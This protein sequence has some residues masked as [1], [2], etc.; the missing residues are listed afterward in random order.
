MARSSKAAAGV[1]DLGSTVHH[2]NIPRYLS[3]GMSTGSDLRPYQGPGDHPSPLDLS[4][5]KTSS[6]TP[7]EHHRERS[8]SRERRSGHE[9]NGPLDLSGYKHIQTPNSQFVSS[10][11]LGSVGSM[12]EKS[13]A[14]S[15]SALTLT[16]SGPHIQ[17][18]VPA[19]AV[20]GMVLPSSHGGSNGQQHPYPIPTM[21]AVQPSSVAGLYPLS[22]LA[23]TVPLLAPIQMQSSSAPPSP[24]HN[25][26]YEHGVHARRSSYSLAPPLGRSAKSAS[27]TP[28]AASSAVSPQEPSRQVP[29]SSL[30]HQSS[31]HPTQSSG[32]KILPYQGGTI[33]IQPSAIH[34]TS[35]HQKTVTL[36][37]QFMTRS[38]P[39]PPPRLYS[40]QTPTPSSPTPR[41][42]STVP[43]PG[44]HI[45]SEPNSDEEHSHWRPRSK[46]ADSTP[47]EPTGDNEE[48]RVGS[49]KTP[50]EKSAN[51]ESDI[52]P[53]KSQTPVSSSPQ[54]TV[55]IKIEAET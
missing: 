32:A 12:I 47:K 5:K 1:V 9:P 29:T 26:S 7:L 35:P 49:A 11:R 39:A 42:S 31:P 46:E 54:P 22:T 19:M 55:Q 25:K 37:S 8:N 13:V 45:K 34:T 24:S 33:M 6:H 44:V 21:F 4:G 51:Q 30:H 18:G 23:G 2:V 17:A 27:P 20:P 50:D 3:P 40:P 10:Q 28:S 36:E 16:Q 41:L 38:S 48:E 43:P 53:A 52:S 14:T 15:V